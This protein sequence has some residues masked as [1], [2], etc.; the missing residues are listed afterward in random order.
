MCGSSAGVVCLSPLFA[1]CIRRYGWQRTVRLQAALFAA[2]ALLSLAFRRI[3]PSRLL[4]D[5]EPDDDAPGGAALPLPLDECADAISDTSS[6]IEFSYI[7]GM[8][9][10]GARATEMRTTA[11]GRE[12]LAPGAEQF[13][14]Q[15]HR[16]GAVSMR[17]FRSRG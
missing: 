2:C 8:V 10:A 16:T 1:A 5:E 9:P 12:A 15:S 13:S 3:A 14:T 17:T 11:S 4:I 6:Q 7:Y